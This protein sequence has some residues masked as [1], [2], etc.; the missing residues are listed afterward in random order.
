MLAK[1]AAKILY[2]IISIIDW[3]YR[4]RYIGFE[5]IKESQE[6]SKYGSY[7]FALWHQHFL[8]GNFAQRNVPHVVLVSRSKDGDLIAWTCRKLGFIPCR[9]SSMKAGVNKGGKAAKEE[10][11][12]KMMTGLPGALTVDGPKGPAKEA[13]MGIID[14]AK[15]SGHPIVPYVPVAESYWQF[16]SWDKFRFPKPF[17]RIIVSYGKPI[18]VAEDLDYENFHE[19]KDKIKCSLEEDEKKAYQYF[20]ED[21]KKL[22]KDNYP[23]FLNET[24]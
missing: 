21:F 20:N 8:Q 11:I 6:K 23:K 19:I 18:F 15:K 14:M 17:S 4:Y 3:T 10:M 24:L 22:S 5:N 7:I 2:Y 16:K 1:L 13:K 9:G 12:Q